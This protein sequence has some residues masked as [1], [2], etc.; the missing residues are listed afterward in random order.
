MKPVIM[1]I[2]R[3]FPAPVGAEKHEHFPRSTWKETSL[4]AS[5]AAE[6]FAQSLNFNH[7]NF[8]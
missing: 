2:G 4:T 7:F 8:Q 1:R 6:R 3:D 5:L